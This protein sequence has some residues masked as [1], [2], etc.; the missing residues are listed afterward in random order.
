MF[1]RRGTVENFKNWN[2]IFESE[3]WKSDSQYLCIRYRR[4]SF[5]LI[6]ELHLHALDYPNFYNILLYTEPRFFL[7]TNAIGVP[8][9]FY[10]QHALDLPAKEYMIYSSATNKRLDEVE[11]KQKFIQVTEDLDE[12]AKCFLEGD[13][14]AIK[15]IG[16]Q[17]QHYAR[18]IQAPPNQALKLTE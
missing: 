3:V 17:F 11:L 2:L 8:L 7:S 12:F 14:K 5:V 13:M 10:K 9:W 18:S 4:K 6:I 1:E 16:K 15:K